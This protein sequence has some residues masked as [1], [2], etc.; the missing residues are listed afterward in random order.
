MKTAQRELVQERAQLTR[1]KLLKAAIGLF[2]ERGY[3]A[4]GT[5]DVEAEAGVNRGLITYHF[6]SKEA[7]WK[8]VIKALFD[9]QFEDLALVQRDADGLDPVEKLASAIRR[10]VE[11]SAHRP[12]LNR[13]MVQEG[14]H[15]DWR[16]AWIVDRHVKPYYATT[17]RLYDDVVAQGVAPP[18]DHVHFH[19]IL[20]GAA[21]L[22]FAM[23]PEC[24]RLSGR[25]PTDSKM[26]AAHADALVR[27]L[28][29]GAN[30]ETRNVHARTKDPNRP[31]GRRRADRPGGG[32]TGAAGGHE[33]IPR[34]RRRRV[35][36]R[37][38]R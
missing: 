22:I 10:F 26:V 28:L 16:L 25:D 2:A 33:D 36:T 37:T 17:K 23:A 8:A 19:Y 24:R 38:K 35:A 13:I 12:E 5:R 20:V 9:D 30:D 34:S 11:Y 4:V 15:D 21:A 7:L 14:K 31:G 27:L 6:G 3:D 29:P 1:D 18:M 32:G